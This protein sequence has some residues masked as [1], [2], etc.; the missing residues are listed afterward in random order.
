MAKIETTPFDAADYLGSAEDIAAYLD[1]YLE[2]GTLAELLS[3]LN[4][5]A[6]SHGMT[7][8]AQKTGITRAGLYKANGSCKHGSETNQAVARRVASKLL[9]K[10]WGLTSS[11]GSMSR[12]EG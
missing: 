6:R 9:K 3:A 2:D 8:L 12:R 4:T 5:V 10:D 7:D 11:L 1:A